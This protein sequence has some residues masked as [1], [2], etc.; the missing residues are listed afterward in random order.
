MVFNY[1]PS[2]P[3]KAGYIG[4]RKPKVNIGGYQQ[5]NFASLGVDDPVGYRLGTY[6]VG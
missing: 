3:L 6:G 5:L 1:S 2:P 4:V